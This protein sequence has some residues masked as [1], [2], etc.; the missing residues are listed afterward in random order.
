[1]QD[2]VW[3]ENEGPNVVEQSPRGR[4]LKAL[5]SIDLLKARLA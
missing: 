2:V 4:L 5:Y 3:L 1:M